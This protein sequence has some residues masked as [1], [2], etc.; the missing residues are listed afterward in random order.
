[1]KLN[2][3]F[4]RTNFSTFSKK[5]KVSEDE[6]SSIHRFASINPKPKIALPKSPT[7]KIDVN[8]N[9]SLSSIIQER[10]NIDIAKLSITQQSGTANDQDNNEETKSKEIVQNV[11]KLNIPNKSMISVSDNNAIGFPIIQE[12]GC[13]AEAS[14]AHSSDGNSKI[15]TQEPTQWNTQSQLVEQQV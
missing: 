14:E 12:H 5:S 8:Q 7:V 13:S 1:M 2:S 6:S 15:K 11:P 10:T 4:E 9:S 3:M